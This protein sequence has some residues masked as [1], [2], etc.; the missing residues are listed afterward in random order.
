M[1][2]GESVLQRA[3]QRRARALRRVGRLIKGRWYLSA[4]LGSGGMAAVFEATD[5]RGR[6]AALKVLHAE[7]LPDSSACERF[8]REAWVARTVQH[9]CLVTVFDEGTTELGEPFLV[10]EQLH[11]STVERLWKRAKKRLPAPVVLRVAERTLDLISTCHRVGVIHRDLKPANLYIT[12]A[13]DVKVLDFGIASIRDVADL[14]EGVAVGTPSFMS[15]EQAAGAW[16]HVD[17]TTD[18]FAVGATMYTLLSGERLH[19]GDTERAGFELAATVPAQSLASV[20]PAASPALIA[21]VDRALAW[22]KNARWPDAEAMREEVIRLLDEVDDG[23]ST[24]TGAMSKDLERSSLVT[25]GHRPTVPP[26]VSRRPPSD[27]GRPP[28]RIPPPPGLPHDLEDVRAG[29]SRQKTLRS[30][31][32]AFQMLERLLGDLGQDGFTSGS[33]RERLSATHALL[34]RAIRSA[35]APIR[36]GLFPFCVTWESDTIWEPEPPLDTVPHALF[37]AGIR[38]IRLHPGLASED[39]R[40]L[41]EMLT[42]STASSTQLELQAAVGGSIQHI[43]FESVVVSLQGDVRQREATLAEAEAIGDAWRAAVLEGGG[44]RALASEPAPALLKRELSADVAESSARLAAAIVEEYTLLR[45]QATEAVVWSPLRNAARHAEGDAWL[46]AFLLYS[47]VRQTLQERVDTKGSQDGATKILAGVL[48]DE[49]MRAMLGG[50]ARLRADLVS[51][52]SPVRDITPD[53]VIGWVAEL[54]TAVGP[55]SFPAVLD[56]LGAMTDP[57]VEDA[58]ASFIERHVAGR[59]TLVADALPGMP[60]RIADRLIGMLHDLETDEARESV[61]QL[62]IGSMSPLRLLA[63]GWLGLASPATKSAIIQRLTDPE[64]SV[65]WAAIRTATR[66]RVVEAVGECEHRVQSRDFH[67]LPEEERAL[68]LE[69]LA[70]LARESC[71]QLAVRLLSKHGIMGD[72]RLD[73]SRIIAAGVL[74]SVA[75][76]T[77]AEA[78]LRAASTPLW[79]NPPAVRIAAKAAHANMQRR[80]SAAQG[81]GR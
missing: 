4:L 76:T 29:E 28:S 74:G 66:L 25:G 45:G 49:D 26:T 6:H 13:G 17:Q 71:E 70:E 77:A 64:P 43:G 27:A 62:A 23:T 16:T 41:V 47:Q 5:L 57:L 79:W 50:A 37:A 44:R 61:L 8:D 69:L 54:L 2:D 19:E 3:R 42:D 80:L 59:E 22:D 60:V 68:L 56:S 67:E 81:V 18:I 53:G 75:T 7:L 34:S 58:L 55:Q 40:R 46:T 30:L 65:R 35:D 21:L 24:L 38:A 72:R 39:L 51:G 14:P 11:G 31:M 12:H 1:V 73:A 9:P 32:E 33:F 20:V 15:P 63:T 78:A 48:R 10:M 36:L 52:R